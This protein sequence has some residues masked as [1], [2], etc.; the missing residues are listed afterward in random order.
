MTTQRFDQW[1]QQGAALTDP[2]RQCRTLQIDTFPGIDRR[3][4][5]ERQVI[6]EVG[7]EDMSE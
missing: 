6:E 3:L 7:R 5:I 4:A 1:S 2:S